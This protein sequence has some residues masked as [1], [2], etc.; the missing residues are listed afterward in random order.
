MK[1]LD[2]DLEKYLFDVLSEG[3]KTIVLISPYIGF[4]MASKLLAYKNK[5]DGLSIKII[6]TFNRQ[7]FIES[8]SSLNGLKI[9]VAKG[10]EVYALK[11]LHTK[12]YLIDDTYCLT[13]SANFTSNGLKYNHEVLVYFDQPN[14]VQ[15]FSLYAKKLFNAVNEW[16]VTLNRIEVEEAKI[17]TFLRP[18]DTEKSATI[19]WGA[20]LEPENEK[21]PVLSVPSGHT[22]ELVHDY[23]IHAHPL[24]KSYR[25]AKTDYITFRQANGGMMDCIYEI[26]D[27]YSIQM[28][29]WAEEISMLSIDENIKGNLTHYIQKRNEGLKFKQAPI[30]KFYSLKLYCDLPNRPRPKRNNVGGWLYELEELRTSDQYVET[31]TRREAR[32]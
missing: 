28:N 32:K 10:V 22:F 13:G 12:M 9:L 7:S 5:H 3:K 27:T 14:E 29:H 17:Q 4:E 16:S 30:Y 26:S 18:C 19:E 15:P 20:E 11:G 6:T 2:R 8:A 23:H 21:I 31:M 24:T 1:L 25:Y